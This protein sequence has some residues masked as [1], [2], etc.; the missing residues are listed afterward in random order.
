MKDFFGLGD[1]DPTESQR[2]RN[3]RLRYYR[4]QLKDKEL[5]KDLDDDVLMDSQNLRY[6]HDPLRSRVRQSELSQSRTTPLSSTSTYTRAGNQ[7]G[8]RRF[9]KESVVKMTAKAVKTIAVS[10]VICI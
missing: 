6:I 5:Q 10:C 8:Q 2:W 7:M 1:E 3:R 9:R 4:G